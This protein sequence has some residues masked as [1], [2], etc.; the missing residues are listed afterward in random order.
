MPMRSRRLR[1]S[2]SRRSI[3]PYRI[4][5]P[6]GSYSRR[7][8]FINV[9]LP[10]P[11]SPTSA[12]FSPGSMRKVTPVSAGRSPPGYWNE[13]SS[14]STVCERAAGSARGFP[15]GLSPVDP[16]DRGE[17]GLDRL[18]PLPERSQI[19]RQIAERDPR[20]RRAI[21]HVEVA[22]VEGEQRERSEDEPRPG[23]PQGEL[24]ILA[25]ELFEIGP[26]PG[27]DERR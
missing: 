25:I 27:K 13:T 19:E 23:L 24:A 1:G 4:R 9:D 26:V 20:P 12:S 5:P 18:L 17:G 2:M 3:P 7:S 8:S 6:L 21:G 11:L 10:A 22:R 16:A 15:R 14:N